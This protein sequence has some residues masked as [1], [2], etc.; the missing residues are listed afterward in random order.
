[1]ATGVCTSLD[2]TECR[3]AVMLWK[4]FAPL[5]LVVGV[6]GNIMSLMV[7]SRQRMR[8]TTTS[9]Y[10]RLLAI[11]DTV[12][13]IV[14]MPRQILSF[15]SFVKIH[16]LSVFT[17]KFYSFMTPVILTLSWY[18]LPIISIDRL[19][20]VRYP[21]WAKKHCTKKSALII[22]TV[23]ALVILATNLHSLI[24]QELRWRAA[25]V[26]TN[27]TNT[28]VRLNA[29]CGAVDP[30]VL[31]FQKNVYPWFFLVV[32][33][34][35]PVML[36]I[37]CNVILIRELVIRSRRRQNNRALKDHNER[38]ERE[39][40]D[41]RSVTRMLVV[42]SVFFVLSS[43]PQCSQIILQYYLFQPKTPHNHAKD[44]L[45]KACVHLLMYS[46]NTIN[47]LLYTLSG[48]LFRNELYSMFRQTRNRVLE[49]FGRN[50]II[51]VESS[52]VRQEPSATDQR[53][54]IATIATVSTQTK[55][56]KVDSESRVTQ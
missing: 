33:S 31:E 22:F 36:Q 49:R 15:Y 26:P 40:K 9:V 14:T 6:L 34:L 8:Q 16:D 27:A 45:F 2:F 38:D 3:F 39:Q 18:I 17:C 13:L 10:L 5:C 28:T 21:L 29:V 51:P 32:F 4:I 24:F 12:V 35:T 47:F 50:A 53:V 54:K 11:V 48:K 42:T 46:N 56:T 43:V 19:I 1:M 25:R 20:Q 37:V 41:L 52:S 30:R 7:L 55:T 44:T 23:L